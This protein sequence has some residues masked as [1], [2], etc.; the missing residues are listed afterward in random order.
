MSEHLN[1]LLNAVVP[2]R[3][4]NTLEILQVGLKSSTILSIVLCYIFMQAEQITDQFGLEQRT[5]RLVQSIRTHH[6]L[7]K[8]DFSIQLG[9]WCQGQQLLLLK[10]KTCNNSRSE[11]IRQRQ[12]L[13]R[14]RMTVDP[15]DE[16]KAIKFGFSRMIKRVLLVAQSS[17]D[18]G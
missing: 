3:F 15:V 4:D 10:F 8:T 16:E 6:H 2:S 7:S 13:W 18:V 17:G 12:A 11:N 1:I 14:K 5:V 9:A